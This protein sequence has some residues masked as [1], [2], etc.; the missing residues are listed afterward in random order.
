MS[1]SEAENSKGRETVLERCKLCQNMMSTQNR[2]RSMV[3]DH[4]GGKKCTHHT[5]F[6]QELFNSII[7]VEL[8]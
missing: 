8:K 7:G 5:L 3:V 1:N 6:V 2:V 4:V